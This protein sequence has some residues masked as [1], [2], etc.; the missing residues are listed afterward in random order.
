MI[1]G[2]LD[3][4]PEKYEFISLGGGKDHPEYQPIAPEQYGDKWQIFPVEG[5]GNP[6]HIRSALKGRKPD[7]L[8][9]MTDPRFYE[10]KWNMEDEIRPHLPTVYYTIWDNYPY[11]EFNN[12]YYESTDVLVAISKLTKDIVEEVAPDVDQY[13][14]PHAV[15]TTVYRPYPRKEME[16]FMQEGVWSRLEDK[17]VF[18]FNGRNARRKQTG[19]MIYW[20]KKFLEKVGKNKAS[21][22]MHTDPKDENGPDLERIAADF[23]LNDGQV[24]FSTEKVPSESLA[25][26]YNAVDCTL[27]LS[28]A[29]GWGVPATESLACET[30]VIATE[31]G[32]LQEQIKHDETGL[33]LEPASKAVVGSQRVPY[34]F[35]DRLNEDQVVNALKKMFKM[36]AKERREMGKK[37]KKHVRENYNKNRYVEQW[38]EVLTQVHEKYGSWPNEQYDRWTLEEI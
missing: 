2:L 7:L 1:Q 26:L 30:P 24:V 21:L 28:D 5:Y 34:I 14:I 32:G 27:M 25:K 18:L 35:E 13:R 22:V 9:F 36:P 33:L 20:F 12:I 8:W 38:D 4:Y 31:T 6:Q 11:P 29:E 15:D 16:Q 10:W 37:G 23:G 17:F 19:S 3:K